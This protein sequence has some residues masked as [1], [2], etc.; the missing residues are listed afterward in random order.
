M[1][2]V[3]VALVV[4][5]RTTKKLMPVFVRVRIEPTVTLHSLVSELLHDLCQRTVAAGKQ[6][7][8]VKLFS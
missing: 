4:K 1:C 5:K 3:L 7:G 6:G 8:S 2:V